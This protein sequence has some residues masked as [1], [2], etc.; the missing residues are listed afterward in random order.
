M[1]ERY[2]WVGWLGERDAQMLLICLMDAIEQGSTSE[3][4]R[5]MVAGWR[6]NAHKALRTNNYRASVDNYLEVTVD[7]R[8]YLFRTGRLAPEGQWA[9]RG[10]RRSSEDDAHDQH[11]L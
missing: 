8:P 5:N 7:A 9:R 10:R 1:P 3:A 6:R 2:D 4:L 11:P